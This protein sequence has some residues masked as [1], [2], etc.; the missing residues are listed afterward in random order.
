MDI[1]ADNAKTRPRKVAGVDKIRSEIRALAGD[2]PAAL[3]CFEGLVDGTWCHRRIFAD[4][5]QKNK[6]NRAG[7]IG[8]FLRIN[9]AKTLFKFR[10]NFLKVCEIKADLKLAGG[11]LGNYQW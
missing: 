10:A 6:G 7:I 8:G 2:R 1:C 4:W 3:L 11:T 9:H 5:W